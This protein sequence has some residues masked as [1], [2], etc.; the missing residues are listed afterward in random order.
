MS[1]RVVWFDL[2]ATDLERAMQFY[3][4]VLS[5]EVIEQ[6]PGVAV[7]AA[8]DGAVTGCLYKSED[9]KPSD[10]GALLYFNVDDRLVDA[11]ATA[12]RLGG[13]IDEPPHA[14]GDFGFRAV[15]IDSEGNRI[16]LH[17]Q[18]QT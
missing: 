12:E 4:A 18:G 10:Q 7:I 6:F 9:V 13:R 11:V 16:A 1:N 8:D 15:V 5:T 3:A 2:P 14:I 17:S